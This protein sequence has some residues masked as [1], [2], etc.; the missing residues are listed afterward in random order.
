VSESYDAYQ[1]TF[2][3]ETTKP[4]W[5]PSYL[6]VSED[7]EI[8]SAFVDTDVG[9]WVARHG[10]T[11]SSLQS[12]YEIQKAAGRYIIHLQGGGTGPN[13]NFAALW[14]TQDIPTPRTWRVTGFQNNSA[15]SSHADDLMQAFM[16]ANG[17]RQAQFAV[18]KDGNPLL[19]KGYSWSETT[20]HTTTAS[21]VFLLASLSKAF[22]EATVQTLYD[23]NKLT[24]ATKVYPLLGYT[25]TADPRLQDITV[26]HLLTHFGGLDDTASGF[27]PTYRMREI[28]AAQNTGPEAATVKDIV[29]YMSKYTLDYNPGARFA[30]SNYGYLLLSYVVE[31]V[32][33][34]PYYDYLSSAV[35][36]PGGYDVRKWPTSPSAHIDDPITQESKYTGL[37]AA[38]PQSQT[39][40]ADIFGG[41]DMYKDD[42]YGSAAL[43]ASATTLFICMVCLF[44]S[45]CTQ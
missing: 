45:S 8:S 26:D 40:I 41:D 38:A 17:V 24:P 33:G 5:R 11:A 36:T 35:L 27:D 31:N 10:M 21:D 2:N 30:Y 14:A 3:A 44:T 12:E 32:T 37:N 9:S 4:F 39:L 43:A 28:A 6:S 34:K 20:R 15:A 23:S 16:K 1:T 42:C 22:V 18:A 25:N 7:H 19:Q 29:N 13:A